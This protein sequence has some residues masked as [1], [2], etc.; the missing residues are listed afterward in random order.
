MTG[1]FASS[2][3]SSADEIARFAYAARS[4]VVAVPPSRGD[5]A[6]KWIYRTALGV[7]LLAAVGTVIQS[8][9]RTGPIYTDVVGVV[10]FHGP[11]T[12]ARV[13][14]GDIFKTRIRLSDGTI[15]PAAVPSGMKLTPGATVTIRGYVRPSGRFNYFVIAVQ[16]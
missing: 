7:V 16:K 5:G 9:R 3:S 1:E 4:R 2:E 11:T 8:S 15:V 13:T 6:R 14:R 10:E 12:P